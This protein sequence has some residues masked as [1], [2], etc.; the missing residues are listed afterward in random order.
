MQLD[1]LFETLIG[2]PG[3]HS[4]EPPVH[5]AGRGR[6]PSGH[7]S[8]PF[9]HHHGAPCTNGRHYRHWSGTQG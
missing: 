6:V 1:G 3:N 4:R 9:N 8:I 7:G 5:A 2:G